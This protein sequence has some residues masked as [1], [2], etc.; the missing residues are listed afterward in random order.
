MTQETFP[1]I[2][3]ATQALEKQ[4]TLNETEIDQMNETINSKKQLLRGWRKAS[5]R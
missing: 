1:K 5:L 3:A 2:Q 4:I